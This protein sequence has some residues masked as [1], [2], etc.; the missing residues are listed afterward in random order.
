[1]QNIFEI[2]LSVPSAAHLI[3]TSKPLPGDEPEAIMKMSDLN[4]K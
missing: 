4:K 1:M 2:I 3:N